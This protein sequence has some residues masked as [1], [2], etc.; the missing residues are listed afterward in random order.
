MCMIQINSYTTFQSNHI[1]ICDIYN[2]NYNIPNIQDL[3]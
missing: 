2:K 1:H 3:I